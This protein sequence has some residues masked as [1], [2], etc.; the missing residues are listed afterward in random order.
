MVIQILLINKSLKHVSNII[1]KYEKI[2]I[3]VENMY[4]RLSHQVN[5][6]E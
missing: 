3:Y 2:S 5:I 4:N 1:K 6:Y